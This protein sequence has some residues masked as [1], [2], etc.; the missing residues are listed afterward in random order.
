MSPTP[1]FEIQQSLTRIGK[2]R[3]GDRTEKGAP[4]KLSAWRITSPVKEVI[5]SA[6]GLYGGEPKPWRSPTGDEWEVY[7]E[8]NELP[9]WIFPSYSLRQQYELWEGVSKCTRRCDGVDETVSGEPCLCNA[10][11]VDECDLYSRMSVALPELA[12]TQGFELVSSGWYAARELK[13]AMTIGAALANG[14]FKIDAVLRLTERRGQRDGSTTRFVVPVVDYRVSLSKTLLVHPTAALEAEEKPLE[15][16]AGY[17]TLDEELRRK[18]TPNLEDGIETV[19]REDRRAK[20]A[21]SAEEIADDDIEVIEE[22][23]VED[24]DAPPPSSPTAGE[25]RPDKPKREP[26]STDD[27]PVTAAMKKKLDVL[28]GDLRDR[29]NLIATKH[30]WGAVRDSLVARDAPIT[31]PIPDD[32]GVIHWAPLREQL[33]RKEAHDLIDRLEKLQSD[34]DKAGAE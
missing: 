26:T 34:M 25:E 2:I 13:G 19:T 29:R 24:P 21:R 28:V 3:A 32:E 10:A 33:T 20:T 22:I 6:A 1:I 16:E 4:R 7:T 5:L 12:T 23:V 27:K 14:D 31:D 15:L 17:G 9:V 8:R 11:G 30:L 18:N